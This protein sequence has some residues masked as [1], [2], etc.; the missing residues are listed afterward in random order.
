MVVADRHG[1][2]HAWNSAAER[3]FGYSSDEA[4][5]RELALL[6]SESDRVAWVGFPEVTQILRALRRDGSEVLVEVSTSR[7][8][9]H[10][11]G[12]HSLSVFRERSAEGA[13]RDRSGE[14]ESL[15]RSLIDSL[16]QK[17]WI[18]DMEGNTQY[19]SPQWYAYTGASDASASAPTV[20]F[21]NPS[22]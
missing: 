22:G 20:A 5:G 21:R 8:E 19:F 7:A 3:L 10:A 1:R 2:I 6:I 14:K 12:S 13:A 17:V 16:P 9:A 15:F 4:G 18:A 11:E